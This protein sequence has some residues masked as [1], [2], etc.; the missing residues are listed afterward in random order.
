LFNFLVGGA[1]GDGIFSAGNLFSK[2]MTRNSYYCHYYTE[3]PSLI[4]GGHNMVTVRVSDQPIACQV[5]HID[6]LFA[7][8]QETISF[9]V[10]KVTP[11]GAVIFDPRI[12]RRKTVEDFNRPDINWIGVPL[13]DLA[14]SIGG[15]KVIQNTIGVAAAVALVDLPSE[16]LADILREMFAHKP[17]VAEINVKAAE[18]GYSYIK[19]HFE[20]FKA[21][22]EDKEDH[23]FMMITGNTAVASGLIAGGISL[24]TGY[25]MSPATSL[26]EAMVKY[27]S[28]FDYMTIQCEDEIS[29]VTMAIGSNHAGGR[30]ATATS[31]GGLSLMVEAIG[32][33][34][35]AEIPL[36]IIDVMRPGPSTGLPTWTGQGD[37][38]FAIRLG[39]DS[40]PRI[41]IAPGDV[42]ECFHVGVEALN[43][44]EEYQLPV[45]VLTDKWLG[46][47]GFTDKPFNQRD[48]TIRKGKTIL[49]DEE[50]DFEDYRRYAITE[51][52]ISPRA[53]P[54]LP[55]NMIFRATGNEHDQFGI[56]DDTAPIRVEQMAKRMKKLEIVSKRLPDPI[57][58][59]HS[60]DEADVTIFSW[61]SNK[62]I[63]LDV[64]DR[65]DNLKVSF[66]H[67]S[68]IWP[69][70]SEFIQ[71]AIDKSAKTILIEQN[72]DAQFGQLIRNH[73][74]RDIP[75]KI[76]RSDGRPHDPIE[77]FNQIRK[78]VG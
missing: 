72:Y 4:R 9:H 6:I 20:Q 23:G 42:E 55:A 53:V 8:N 61:G 68:Y 41:V 49:L 17:A 28:Q 1:A 30:A 21:K 31:G 12:L 54:G 22:L 66:V 67:T 59:G 3:Y 65:L 73:C 5:S 78:N 35:S 19:E 57:I 64:M 18:L 51:D 37:L 34:G 32:L 44:A 24:F 56:V 46:S 48:V 40:F 38:L 47:S 14:K 10:Q 26:L 50:P 36:V 71:N 45:I 75:Y 76:L 7:I 25:P 13:R 63:I 2:M 39:Q 43:L 33:A 60:P 11:G 15:A 62:Q 27:A 29:A 58:Y 70:P 69:F 74:L 52:G 16:E 77:I